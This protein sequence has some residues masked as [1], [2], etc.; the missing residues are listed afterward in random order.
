MIKISS[1]F[2]SIVKNHNSPTSKWTA[3]KYHCTQNCCQDEGLRRLNVCSERIRYQKFRNHKCYLKHLDISLS[4]VVGK[5]YTLNGQYVSFIVNHNT[6]L[7]LNILVSVVKNN[8]PLNF[9]FKYSRHLKRSF[10]FQFFYF[11]LRCS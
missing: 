2:P 4:L 5:A 10:I 7:F 3:D 9:F 8:F 6:H 11:I 1:L